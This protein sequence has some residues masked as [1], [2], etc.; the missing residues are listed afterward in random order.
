[1]NTSIH[2][3]A[4]FIVM[5]GACARHE[6]SS[7]LQARI[8]QSTY[9]GSHVV[10]ADVFGAE[11]RGLTRVDDTAVFTGQSP[12]MDEMVRRSNVYFTALALKPMFQ[13]ES[14]RL[15]CYDYF[16]DVISGMTADHLLAIELAVKGFMRS[17]LVDQVYMTDGEVNCTAMAE[18]AI[19]EFDLDASKDAP[20]W[21]WAFEM[22]QWWESLGAQS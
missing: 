12:Q 16:T 8:I 11:V 13:I 1:M 17:G 19:R 22:G 9:P 5:D 20:V 14:Y 7:L 4:T 10:S 6:G 3:M 18:D 15:R 21:T 2:P